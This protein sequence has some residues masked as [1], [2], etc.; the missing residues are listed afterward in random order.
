[1]K[2]LDSL[3]IEKIKNII[4][5]T[6]AKALDEITNFA[7]II[8]LIKVDNELHVIFELRAKDMRTQPGEVSFPGGKLEEGE[9]FQEAAIRETM[10]ELNIGREKIEVIGELDYL[11]SYS[12]MRINS[13]LANISGVD[14]D[15]I[16]PNPG[17]VDHLFTVPLKFFLENEP[18]GYYLDL[19][20][21]YNKEFPYSLLPNGKDYKFRKKRRTIYI[22]EYDGYIIWGYTASMLKSFIDKIKSSYK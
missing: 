20:T 11:I 5:N 13:F 4:K 19:E 6:K 7:V 1:M 8:P 12:N 10:E 18:N 17:E 15:K 22:Y 9:S 16:L 21:K 2:F 14:V 3:N